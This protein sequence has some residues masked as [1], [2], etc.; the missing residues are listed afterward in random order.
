MRADAGMRLI[1]HDELRTGSRK[2]VA[3][4]VRLDVVETDNG[5]G[6]RIE[7]RLRGR[8][9]T[10]EARRR[11]GG[12]RRRI[13]VELRLYQLQEGQAKRAFCVP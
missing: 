13:E 6:V 1:D 11:R 10:F 8:Q 3:A 4:L 9:S 5:V 12:D 2:S 7:Q